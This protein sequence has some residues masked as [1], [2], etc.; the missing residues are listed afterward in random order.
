MTRRTGRGVMRLSPE[1]TNKPVAMSSPL[2]STLSLP[3]SVRSRYFTVRFFR[4]LGRFFFSRRFL[5]TIV[6][7]A[8]LVVL[9]YQ[10][11]NWNGARELKAARARMLATAGTEDYM[12]LVPPTLPEEENYFALPVIKSWREPSQYGA[13][14][15]STRFP[16]DNLLPKGFTKP[17]IKDE[18][19]RT[20]L[21]LAGWAATQ[22]G[23]AGTGG[24]DT[25]VA[26]CK[27][28]GDG[29][30]VI[31]QLIA[32]LDRSGSQLI[33][34]RREILEEAG[35]NPV[36]AG[37]P[38]CTNCYTTAL[39]LEIHL[40]AAAL[41]GDAGKTRDIA[42]VM[43]KLAD[44]FDHDPGLVSMLVGM[45]MNGITLKAL[46]EALA[47]PSLQ[48]ADFRRIQQWLGAAD[49]LQRT[50]NTFIHQMLVSNSVFASFL[51]IQA[52]QMSKTSAR[53]GLRSEDGFMKYLAYSASFGP[54]GWMDTNQAFVLE[55]LARTCGEPGDEGWRAGINGN[56]YMQDAVR[57]AAG[58]RLGSKTFVNPRRVLGV[59]HVPAMSGVWE[60]AAKNEFRRRC[61]ILTCALH[62]HRL[63]QG[64][65]PASLAELT[66]SLLPSPQ[67]D[68]AKA[69]VP[70]GYRRTETGFLLWSTGHDRNDDG[71]DAEKDWTWRHEFSPAGA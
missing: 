35:G 65:F 68:P 44:G 14:G 25:A 48:D 41:A 26:L 13:G 31:P 29:N 50:R 69:G 37:I 2:A 62:R 46:D 12:T 20:R 5:W 1:R 24:R 71:G 15:F 70:F 17:E 49:D 54:S 60:S 38:A 34:S 45:A 28:L 56:R 4:W 19:G 27:A 47:C 3:V 64:A 61:A 23:S 51:R 30:G 57:T 42:G 52:K 39:S 18:A 55:C 7:L 36:K 66:T 6:I 16:G 21:D 63:A 58:V 33:P 32:G 59:I 11:E 40:R 8:S 53:D 67:T 9:F 43:L 10:Y 22:K